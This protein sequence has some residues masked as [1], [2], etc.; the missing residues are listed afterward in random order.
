MR[1]LGRTGL[2]ISPVGFGCHRLEDVN[3]RD[4]PRV[5]K[6]AMPKRFHPLA[7]G[8]RCSQGS[9]G[10]G[11][12]SRMQLSSSPAARAT[13]VCQLNG[14]WQRWIWLPTIPTVLLKRLGLILVRPLPLQQIS[15]QVAGEVLQKMLQSR[16]DRHVNTGSLTVHCYRNLSSPAKLVA[17][18]P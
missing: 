5:P 8:C 13:V 18:A 10:A 11:S 16:K 15:A 2:H 12:L 17:G 3:L 6:R 4:F 7:G 9:I 1:A 14:N